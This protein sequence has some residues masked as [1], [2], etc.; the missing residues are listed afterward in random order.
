MPPSPL[1]CCR[2][3]AQVLTDT[4]F[5]V[6]CWL[7]R[8][9]TL[10]SGPGAGMVASA[11]TVGVREMLTAG[12]FATL[13]LGVFATLTLGVFPTLTVGVFTTLTF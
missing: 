7:A 10:V 8:R 12:V 1:F 6:T 5:S 2:R 3:L 9:P 11:F 13:T 4:T